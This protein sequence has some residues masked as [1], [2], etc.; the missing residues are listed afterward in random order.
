MAITRSPV[1]ASS[2][3]L[4]FSTT[5]TSGL[6]LSLRIASSFAPAAPSSKM[7]RPRATTIGTTQISDDIV[8]GFGGP[9]LDGPKTVWARSQREVKGPGRLRSHLALK[10]DVPRRPLAEQARLPVRQRTNPRLGMEGQLDIAAEIAL[11]SRCCRR[12]NAR[13]SAVREVRL[14]RD[15]APRQR[16]HNR[17][18]PI[19][20]MPT[21]AAARN[22][23]TA[24]SGAAAHK[25]A[26]AIGR[27]LRRSAIGACRR[28]STRFGARPCEAGSRASCRGKRAEPLASGGLHQ[29]LYAPAG[30]KRRTIALA[31]EPFDHRHGLAELSVAKTPACF[32]TNPRRPE[33]SASPVTTSR[34]PSFSGMISQAHSHRRIGPLRYSRTWKIRQ[35]SCHSP[36]SSSHRAQNGP[37]LPWTKRR[38]RPSPST[39]SSKRK[40]AKPFNSQRRAV[41]ETNGQIAAAGLAKRRSWR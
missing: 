9:G 12:S 32:P 25:F 23:S 21:R 26:S 20:T 28:K 2:P 24:R 39:R 15:F 30:D 10:L 14:T 33:G 36:N 34:Q 13:L 11:R 27:M 5:K 35:F 1:S 7:S 31:N 19:A 40:G 18:H 8:I 22:S 37:A 17:S 41:S 29:V 16:G 6:S 38:T 3:Q 4:R